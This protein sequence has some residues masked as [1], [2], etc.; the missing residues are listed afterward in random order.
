VVLGVALV[1]LLAYRINGTSAV[2][3]F[4]YPGTLG[5]LLML[6]SYFVCN[7]GAIVFLYLRG[8]RRA[9]ALEIVIPLIALA[10][11]VYVLYQNTLADSLVYPYTVFRR[12]LAAARPAHRR[13]RARP[14]A[15]CGGGARAR[16][17]AASGGLRPLVHEAFARLERRFEV[18]QR[19]RA[20]E[21]DLSARLGG[22]EVPHVKRHAARP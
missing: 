12:R 11:I 8:E 9:P 15:P 19:R 14:R 13:A 1:A 5:V 10:I 7:T 6:V 3:A 4:F 16:G 17:G 18:A 21:L 20:G 22:P 2:N